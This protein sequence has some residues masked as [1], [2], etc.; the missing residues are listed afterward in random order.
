MEV[1]GPETESEPQARAYSAAAAIPD[2]LTLCT[3][4]GIESVPPMRPELLQLDS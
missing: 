1:P 2:P 4:Q 3:R